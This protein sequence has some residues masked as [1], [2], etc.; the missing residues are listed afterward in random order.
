MKLMNKLIFSSLL[1]CMIPLSFA[2]PADDQTLQKNLAYGKLIELNQYSPEHEKGL[3]L[4]LF[5]LPSHDEECGLE[6]SGVC[7]NQHLLTAASFDE[8]PDTQAYSL[9]TKGEFVKADWIESSNKAAI[10]DQAELIL[11]F[12]EHHR[13]ATRANPNLARKSF[14]VRVKITPQGIEETVLAK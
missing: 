10:P 1:L 12:R 13:F 9:Q 7:K 2:Q 14:K 8:M 5:S 3:L 11:T 4:R 6:T